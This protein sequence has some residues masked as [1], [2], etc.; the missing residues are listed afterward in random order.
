MNIEEVEDLI[1]DLV[2][3]LYVD[4]ILPNHK[5]KD[6]LLEIIRLKLEER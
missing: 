1:D 4:I 3:V 5:S 6:E 2:N